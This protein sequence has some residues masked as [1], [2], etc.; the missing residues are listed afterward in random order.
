M[1]LAC[2]CEKVIDGMERLKYGIKKYEEFIIQR[3]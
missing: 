2:Q 1:N 3:C